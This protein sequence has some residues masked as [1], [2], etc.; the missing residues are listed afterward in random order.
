MKKV[1]IVEDDPFVR[2]FYER[3]FKDR[4]YEV[5]LA[6]NG[7]IGIQLINENKPTL[8]LLDIMMTPMSGLQVLEVLKNQNETKFIPIVMLTNI[9]DHATIKEAQRLG[10][11][12]F[13][14]KAKYEP[15]ELRSQIENMIAEK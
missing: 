13:M 3:L 8:I 6:E 4:D 1:I 15:D 12:G 2:K 5:L 7:E 9:D 11:D 10:A 14:V